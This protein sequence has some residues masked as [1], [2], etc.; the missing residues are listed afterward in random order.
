[1]S[2]L[3]KVTKRSIQYSKKKNSCQM[4]GITSSGFWPFTRLSPELISGCFSELDKEMSAFLLTSAQ[5]SS[6]GINCP[7]RE[8]IPGTLEYLEGDTLVPG[9]GRVAKRQYLSPDPVPCWKW[10]E[11]KSSDQRIIKIIL[12]RKIMTPAVQQELLLY[13]WESPP[14]L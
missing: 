12:G 5:Y 4:A 11:Y 2:S 13:P 14:H 10:I 6:S 3:Q 8:M 7:S 1:M 9:G